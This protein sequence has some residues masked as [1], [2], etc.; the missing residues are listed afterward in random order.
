MNYNDYNDNELLY[1]VSENNEDANEI[2]FK[3]YEPLIK[4]TANDMYKYC[5]NSGLELND[6]IQEGM[7]AL[8][9]AIEKYKE[10]KNIKFSLFAKTCVKRRLISI[11]LS[12]KR[13]KNRALNDSIS[14]E[15]PEDEKYKF[16]H[17][18]S[19][20]SFN[21]ENLVLNHEYNKSLFENIKNS[22]TNLEFQVFEMKMAGFSY[23]EIEEMLEKDHKA[24]DNAVQRLR[25]KI[26][27]IIE[28]LAV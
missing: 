8:N 6:L 21:P 28:E 12:T 18:F 14:F 26:R 15:L 11:V 16:D 25:L 3:K 13:K 20:N 5:K 24:I 2:I 17:I 1:Y 10:E 23:K 7:L 27:K 22:L 19:D 4:A 9:N